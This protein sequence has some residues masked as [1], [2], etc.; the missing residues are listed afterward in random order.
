MT[1]LK[2]QVR[3]PEKLKME[4]ETS[5]DILSLFTVSRFVSENLSKQ[6]LDF[7]FGN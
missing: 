1:R 2:A 6:I 3:E 5:A 4:G 7:Q